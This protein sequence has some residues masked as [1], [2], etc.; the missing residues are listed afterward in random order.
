M[1]LDCANVFAERTNF[2]SLFVA[3]LCDSKMANIELIGRRLFLTFFIFLSVKDTV[4]TR[5]LYFPG[6]LF[7]K[8]S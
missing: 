2:A 3:N 1:L 6:Y 7:L 5:H 8:P 4:E